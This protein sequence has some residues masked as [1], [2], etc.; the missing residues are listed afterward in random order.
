[1]TRQTSSAEQN[2]TLDQKAKMIRLMRLSGAACIVIAMIIYLNLGGIGDLLGLEVNIQK[3][4]AFALL[5]VGFMDIVLV[6]RLLQ[7]IKP[8]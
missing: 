5:F 7:M 8:K 1:M 3:T 2:P 4:I 6:P